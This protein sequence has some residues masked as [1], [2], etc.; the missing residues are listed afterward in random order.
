MIFRDYNSFLILIIRFTN[1]HIMLKVSVKLVVQVLLARVDRLGDFG[2]LRRHVDVF[3]DIVNGD[4]EGG[5]GIDTAT[6]GD[7]NGAEDGLCCQAQ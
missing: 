6:G 5:A 4:N 7:H 2:Q 1:L 3:I